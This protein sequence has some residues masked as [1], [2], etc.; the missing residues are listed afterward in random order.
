M[1][2]EMCIRDRNEKNGNQKAGENKNGNEKDREKNKGETEAP[3]ELLDIVENSGDIMALLDRE[4]Q[5][6]TQRAEAAENSET[7]PQ[8][9]QSRTTDPRLKVKPLSE[10]LKDPHSFEFSMQDLLAEEVCQNALFNLSLSS[11]QY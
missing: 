11:L 7:Q 8:T 3:N 4:V 10:F 9:D 5:K 2:S 1:G 6:A